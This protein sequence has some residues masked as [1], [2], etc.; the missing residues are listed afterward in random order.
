MTRG[1]AATTEAVVESPMQ[2]RP[3]TSPDADQVSD[4]HATPTH[5][6][7]PSPSHAPS[8]L[9]GYAGVPA[10]RHRW[11]PARH[12]HPPGSTGGKNPPMPPPGSI[13]STSLSGAGR[14]GMTPAFASRCRRAEA[15]PACGRERTSPEA[16]AGSVAGYPRR[17]FM[18]QGRE[19][20]SSGR[21]LGRDRELVVRHTRDVDQHAL[22]RPTAARRD[23][24]PDAS[25][26]RS[27]RSRSPGP[28]PGGRSSS[29][30]GG[31]IWF[32]W[33]TPLPAGQPV[34][35]GGGAG[36]WTTAVAFDAAVADP[37]AFRAV[38]RT[39]SRRPTSAATS[40]YA[41]TVAPPIAAQSVPCGFPPLAGHRT[42]WYENE[43][44][45]FDHWPGV[46]VSVEPE[47][48]VPTIV[49]SATRTGGC[50]A[51]VT[52]A[53]ALDA[54]TAEP[55]AFEAV[56]RTRRRDPRSPLETTYA[57]VVA[58]PM[59]AQ[60]EPSGRPPLAGQRTHCEGERGRAPGPGSLGRRQG[61]ADG[62]GTGDRRLSRV[63][64]DCLRR[65]RPDA[66]QCRQHQTKR[67]GER[68]YPEDALPSYARHVNVLSSLHEWRLVSSR[69]RRRVA[70][71][72]AVHKARRAQSMAL[73]TPSAV[74][75]ACVRIRSHAFDAVVEHSGC[76]RAAGSAG[77]FGGHSWLRKRSTEPSDVGA[78]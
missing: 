75:P 2:F 5:D 49:G 37:S 25:G 74:R 60:S 64:G 57:C 17:R 50:D 21:R 28:S 38:T 9:V 66:G 32:G 22:D 46:A 10:L 72:T 36:A 7:A 4:R 78:Q 54:A 53:V 20:I 18:P 62:R 70:E 45:L 14:R 27:R 15:R 26:S 42:H 71:H 29:R 31:V 63:G 56:T 34:T 69:V 55:S 40:W 39:R 30:A 3:P 12:G 13:P 1:Q 6:R 52:A 68:S 43:V 76:G 67:Q 24:E 23:A 35:T 8:S 11:V 44:G 77:G 61:G 19:P 65:G 73:P 58:P 48:A 41:C 33:I 16:A 59:K 51:A 47:R